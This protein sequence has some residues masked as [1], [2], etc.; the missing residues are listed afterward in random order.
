MALD[1]A[2]SREII[3]LRALERAIHDPGPWVIRVPGAS[4]D[5]KRVVL[6]DCVRFTVE[7][8]L[9]D[10]VMIPVLYSRGEWVYSFSP[11]VSANRT[12]AFELA[13]SSRVVA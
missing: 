4:C 1:L 2:V 6:S 5:A 12:H 8:P 7:L 11:L 10:G 13:L 3:K 9:H